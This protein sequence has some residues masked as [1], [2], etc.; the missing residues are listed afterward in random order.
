MSQVFCTL[1]EAAKTL[2]ANE[3]EIQALLARGVLQEFRDGPHRLLKE[4][5]VGAL[6]LKCRQRRADPPSSPARTR[7]SVPSRR[8]KAEDRGQKTEDRKRTTDD[9]TAA[10]AVRRRP[11]A[12]SRP[13]ASRIGPR[14]RRPCAS[15][16]GPA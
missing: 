15:G 3:D 9:Q 12:G 6:A 5:D 16:S 11:S 10:S 1:Q 7:T 4:A 14:S 8:R 2:N 13:P